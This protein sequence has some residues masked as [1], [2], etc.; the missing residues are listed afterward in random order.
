MDAAF[1]RVVCMFLDVL[2]VDFIVWCMDVWVFACVNT[3]IMRQFPNE[4]K[5]REDIL[6]DMWLS[7]MSRL[8]V[9]MFG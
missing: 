6:E 4:T 8:C 7:D 3:S 5:K 2:D 1:L 9:C